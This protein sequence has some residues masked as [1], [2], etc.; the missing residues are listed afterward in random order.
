MDF[1]DLSSA[2][3]IRNINYNVPRMVHVQNDDFAHV[4]AVDFKRTTNKPVAYGA[5]PMEEGNSKKREGQQLESKEQIINN[6]LWK[7]PKRNKV[8]YSERQD[9]D[10][11]DMFLK[12]VHSLPPNQQTCVAKMGFE[13]FLKMP[14]SC[15][16]DNI[17]IWLVKHFNTV[18]SSIEL[19]NGF[20]FSLTPLVVH[21][22]LGIPLG[23]VPVQT[24]PTT[25]TCNLINQHFTMVPP[26][27]EYLI[28]LVSSDLPDETFSRIFML[29]VLS[30][31][32]APNSEGVASQE[33]YSALVDTSSVHKHD[34]C[35]FA[36]SYLLASI[37]N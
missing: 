19:E 18:N 29:I 30:T 32:I 3:P 37:K 12:M 27:A 10:Y 31:I 21:K 34:W 36:L 4:A 5:L 28:S 24:R 25:R 22:I 11:I 13:P 26:S 1:L 7:V 8:S 15:N 2:R 14:T 23:G 6:A 16:V 17:F 20:N 9:L 35:L 33:Y